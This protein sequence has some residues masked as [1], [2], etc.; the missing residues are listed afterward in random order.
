MSQR[1]R[2][3]CGSCGLMVGMYWAPPPPGPMRF[4]PS[5]AQASERVDRRTVRRASLRMV[6]SLFGE[7]IDRP[8]NAMACL[9][10]LEAQAE[11]EFDFTASVGSGEGA[12]DSAGAADVVG[13][14]GV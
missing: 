14:A 5:G 13:S 6:N 8:P 7:A 11:G 9:T 1:I 10:R 4:Q 3:V 12:E 2:T